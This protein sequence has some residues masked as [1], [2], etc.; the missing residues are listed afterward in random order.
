MAWFVFSHSMKT[1]FRFLSDDYHV[2][3][4]F[5]G[6][7]SQLRVYELPT[8][9]FSPCFSTQLE[10][11]PKVCGWD[12]SDLTVA[13]EEVEVDDGFDE[14]DKPVIF[15]SATFVKGGDSIRIKNL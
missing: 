6:D 11:G 2:G 7:A 9:F 14:L 15:T 3:R 8:W 5:K 4:Y 10:S 12:S 1:P 13:G